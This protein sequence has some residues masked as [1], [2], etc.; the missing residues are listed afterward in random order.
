MVNFH[1]EGEGYKNSQCF[2]LLISTVRNTIRKWK[3][4][5]T[6][7]VNVRFGRSRRISDRIAQ[8]LVRNAQKKLHITSKELQTGVGNRGLTDHRTTIQ[9]PFHN[10]DVHGRIVR[11]TDLANCK[12][13]RWIHYALGLCGSWG[14]GKYCGRKNGFHQ[15]LRDSRG[16][17][18]K[19]SP[20]IEVEL[21][22][23]I[24]ARQWSKTS[25][26]SKS[27]MKYL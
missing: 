11:K 7:E 6:V 2:K 27:T 3:I 17:C 15:I 5:G 24:P 14:H 18:S 21:R 23:G 25:K 16:W 1:Q 4:N 19:V 9:P 26:S 13:L 12:A 10:K 20:D 22:L 8:G